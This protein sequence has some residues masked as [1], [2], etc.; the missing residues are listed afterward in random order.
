MTDRVKERLRNH[1]VEFAHRTADAALKRAGV[2][3]SDDFFSRKP[4]E[5]RRATEEAAPEP[6][7]RVA[8]D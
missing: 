6:T 2:R 7:P 8:G 1:T 4:S 3:L 5:K